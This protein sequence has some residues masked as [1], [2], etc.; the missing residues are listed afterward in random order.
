MSD[1]HERFMRRCLELARH[2]LGRTAPNPL[3][4]CVI[5]HQ[6]K[7][8][9]EGYH[10][11][12]GQPHAEVEA[13]R[14]CKQTELLANSTLYVSL[15][16]CAHQGKTPACAPQVVQAGI[17]KVVV[18]NRDPFPQVDGKGK[19]I[20]KEAGVEVVE[21]VLENEGRWLN[22]R[23]FTHIE[24]QRPY[25][26]L[27]WAQSCDGFLDRERQD[28][29]GVRWITGPLAQ[30]WTHRWRAEEQAILVGA[31]TAMTDQPALTVRKAGGRNPIRILLDQHLRVPQTGPLFNSE[32]PTWT[33]NDTRE[34]V[35]SDVRF[36]RVPRTGTFVQ[37]VLL[38]LGKSG[39]QSVLVEGGSR[40]LQSF[41]DAGLWDEARIWTGAE[42]FVAGKP[43]PAIGGTVTERTTVGSDHLEFRLNR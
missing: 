35:D 42:R 1:S 17:R 14:S 2:G 28:E 38:R 4:G 16:P 32:A 23:F 27:K 36:L 10:T 30:N 8:I 21:G 34:S 33:I 26:V 25:V 9:G 18:C 37:D 41:I 7:I 31:G 6:G 22:R 5:V 24:L 40:V 3:V 20:L 39:I 13:L 11:A 15:E 19:A 12:Y 29:V 43:A